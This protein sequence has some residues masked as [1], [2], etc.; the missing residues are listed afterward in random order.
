MVS[1][2]IMRA[3]LEHSFLPCAGPEDFDAP[4]YFQHTLDLALDGLRKR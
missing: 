4:A 2:L 3:I 1:P